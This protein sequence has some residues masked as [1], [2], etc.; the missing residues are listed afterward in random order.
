VENV[1]SKQERNSRAKADR[2]KKE[3]DPEQPQRESVAGA[4]EVSTTAEGVI[5]DIDELL[6]AVD[7][8]LVAMLFKPG[9]FVDPVE[10]ERRAAAMVAQYQQKGGQ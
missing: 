9:E 7:E 8:S 6:D 4:E 2:Q 1:S 3:P 10:L 5:D